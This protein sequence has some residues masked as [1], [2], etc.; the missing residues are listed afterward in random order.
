MPFLS[1]PLRLKGVLKNSVEFDGLS[2]AD[3]F[4]A[5]AAK[6]EA[7]KKGEKKTNFRLRD[8]GVSRQRYWG[9]PV[10]VIYCDDCGT[11]PVPDADL[12]VELPKEDVVLDGSQ[13]PLAA[14]PT[15]PH[16]DCPKCGK[17][18]KKRNRYL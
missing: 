10:P 2:S 12:P 4:N 8:W 13:S 3:A 15:F 11:V 1:K 17:A 6:L 16:A 7:D 18:A 5:I 14:H 9:A